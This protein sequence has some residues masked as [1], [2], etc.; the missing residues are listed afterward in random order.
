[1]KFN[2]ST[3]TQ[4]ILDEYFSTDDVELHTMKAMRPSEDT[5][6]RY[7]RKRRAHY[8]SMTLRQKRR[9]QCR[10]PAHVLASP[11]ESVAQRVLDSRDD[12][13]YVTF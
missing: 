10:Y 2:K 4:F 8:Y 5:F 9:R 7:S 3:L 13:S 6:Q 11:D 12:Q 1:M